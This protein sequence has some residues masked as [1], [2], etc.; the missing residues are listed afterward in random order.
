MERKPDVEKAANGKSGTARLLA[1][2][3][4]DA[5]VEALAKAQRSNDWCERA[6]IAL[7]PNTPENVLTRLAQEGNTVVRALAKRSLKRRKSAAK[8][9][10]KGK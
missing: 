1:F 3:C 6:A 9:R 5:P 10:S 7:H 2:L 4:P 8:P